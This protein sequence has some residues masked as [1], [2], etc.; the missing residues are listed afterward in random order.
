M[1]TAVLITYVASAVASYLMWEWMG[2]RGHDRWTRT[3]SVLVML[4]FPYA[5]VLFGVVGPDALGLALLLTTFVLLERGKLVLAGLCAAAAVTVTI[6]A[7]AVIPALAF[8]AWYRRPGGVHSDQAGGG[9]GIDV[10]GRAGPF[11]RATALVLSLLGPV[12]LTVFSAW[13]R[14]DPWLVWSGDGALGG[15]EPGILRLA[16]WIR[17]GWLLEDSPVSWTLNRSAQTLVLAAFLLSAYW[18]W[19]RFGPA[20]A[21]LV[22]GVVALTLIGFSGVAS[23]GRHLTAA[24]PVAALV[25][26]GFA[27]LPR[28]VA[29]VIVG[30][31]TILMFTFYVLYLRSTG[32]PFW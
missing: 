26:I 6:T 1:T 20:A 16:T 31:S 19:K 14:G 5:F 17:V 15:F 2:Y 23:S 21:T 24:F 22:V 28:V 4:S 10:T 18:V 32:F 11:G 3:W 27:R 25:G 12:A 29:G 13:D 7:L 9:A 30:A 8:F